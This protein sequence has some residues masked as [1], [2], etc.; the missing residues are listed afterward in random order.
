LNYNAL[1]ELD[2]VCSA[3]QQ[4]GG[5]YAYFYDVENCGS[6]NNHE[7][8]KYGTDSV[9]NWHFLHEG[10]VSFWGSWMAVC[11]YVII[12]IASIVLV[13]FVVVRA[14]ERKRRKNESEPVFEGTNFGRLV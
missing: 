11:L 3:I 13:L 8:R 10:G 14:S 1:G 7:S 12:V 4:K 6:W 2:Y 9:G 5:A